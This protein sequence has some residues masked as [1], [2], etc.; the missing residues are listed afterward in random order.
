MAHNPGPTTH[1]AHK[2]RRHPPARIKAFLEDHHGR[3]PVLITD[4]SRY[5][6]SLARAAGVELDERVTIEL[7]SG[8]RLPMRVVWVKGSEAG[9]NFLGPIASGHPVM[10][11]L[12][13][14]AKRL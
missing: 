9:L 3:R 14:A 12:D 11:V 1:D 5:G 4:Y 10:H 7:Q 2:L 13:E 6:L 8:E